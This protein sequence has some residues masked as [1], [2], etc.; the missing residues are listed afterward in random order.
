MDCLKTKNKKTLLVF[1]P[2]E[3][4]Y[5]LILPNYVQV[6]RQKS[7]VTVSEEIV[8]GLRWSR[9]DRRLSLWIAH[10]NNSQR[11]KEN[12]N[13]HVVGEPERL[14][15]CQPIRMSRAKTEGHSLHKKKKKNEKK[16][17]FRLMWQFD[18]FV[19][20][21]VRYFSVLCCFVLFSGFDQGK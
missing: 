7:L 5:L 2:V 15:A 1:R 20:I 6:K 8:T 11:I 10:I 19:C 13:K 14:P 9:F 21:M 18:L 16:K 3:S 17:K 12:A 4:L